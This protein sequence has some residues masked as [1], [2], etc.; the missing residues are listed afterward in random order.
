M[1]NA[2]GILKSVPLTNIPSEVLLDKL[3]PTFATILSF[4]V[5]LCLAVT[6]N[7]E[8]NSLNVL[9][10]ISIDPLAIKW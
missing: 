3:P 7:S 8:F 4:S 5:K 6:K 9:C 2:V 1:K 10:P